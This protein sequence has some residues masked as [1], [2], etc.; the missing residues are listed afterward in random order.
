V[1]RQPSGAS[2]TLSDVRF[3]LVLLAASLGLNVFLARRAWTG[4]PARPRLPTEAEFRDSLAKQRRQPVP[5]PGDGSG[6]VV[7]KFNDYQCP[8]CRMTHEQYAPVLAR[9]QAAHPGEIKLV[10]RDFRW[11]PNATPR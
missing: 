8:P 5:V 10:L 6:V 3:L 4:A 1:H 2:G 7:V 9:L 11:R